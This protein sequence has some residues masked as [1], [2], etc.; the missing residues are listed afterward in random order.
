V[1]HNKPKIS[2]I[3]P[4]Y[5]EE[6]YIFRCLESIAVLN[7]PRECLQVIVV[8]NESTDGSRVVASQF[9]VTVMSSGDKTIGG[10]RNTGA[11]IATGEILAF[12]DADCTV[13]KEW[14]NA[15]VSYLY[16]QQ[17]DVGIVGAYPEVPPNGN[18]LQKTWFSHRTAQ[19]IGQVDYVGSA[20]L[21]IRKKLFEKVG[22]FS[23]VLPSGEDFDLCLRIREAGY[24]VR[25]DYRIMCFH[26]GYP[27]T[28]KAF[29]KR[30]IWHGKG[31]VVDLK[32][33]LHSRPLLL[34]IFYL[35]VNCFIAMSIIGF[36]F[37]HHVMMLYFLVGS[38][39]IQWLPVTLLAAKKS[40]HNRKLSY[41]PLLTF[42]Y[43]IYGVSRSCSLFLIVWD[44]WLERKMKS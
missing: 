8:D 15:F 23:E 38:L 26:Y 20:N 19:M 6:K 33:P 39:L 5:N 21:I 31:M 3:I 42:L 12:V 32:N 29:V 35:T 22:G 25:S 1:L 14:V 16:D 37:S 30:E 27:S 34:A 13:E 9:S 41:F 17:C 2:I 43:Y 44:F 24:Q 18:L 4:C 40:V 36:L 10:V 11:T 7:Y 28:I